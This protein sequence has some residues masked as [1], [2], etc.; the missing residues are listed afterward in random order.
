MRLPAGASPL[1]DR[2][3][4]SCGILPEVLRY[5]ISWSCWALG[6]MDCVMVFMTLERAIRAWMSLRGY[7]MEVRQE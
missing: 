2:S 3:P 6:E 1:G 5:Q 4:R 7:F